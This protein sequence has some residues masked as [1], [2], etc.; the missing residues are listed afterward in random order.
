MVAE[1]RNF[2]RAAARLHIAQPALSAQIRK[3]ERQLGVRLLIRTTRSV[4]LTEAGRLLADRGPAAVALLERTWQAVRQDG[5]DRVHLVYGPSTGYGTV[6]HLIEAAR[7]RLR[8]TP[9]M[10]PTSEIP[11]AVRDGRAQVGIARIAAETPGIRLVALRRE[12]RGVLTSADH[13]LAGRAE[14]DPAAIAGF[15]VLV[16]RRSANPEHFDEISGLFHGVPV[17]LVERPM[18]FDPTQRL[19]RD[20]DTVGIVGEAAAAEMPGWLRWTPIAGAPPQ[21]TRL[22]LPDTAVP[23]ATQAFVELAQAEARRNG[24][25]DDHAGR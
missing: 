6:P 23:A 7:D 14:A 18:T 12:R 21:Q 20:A 2:T 8:L 13:P 17:R 9:E 4:E 11:A 25:L 1:E 24:W 3:L 10:L 22:V 16:H 19:L 15:P 5:Q